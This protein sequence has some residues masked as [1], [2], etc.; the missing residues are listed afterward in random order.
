LLAVEPLEWWHGRRFGVLRVKDEVAGYAA[1]EDGVVVAI[2]GA[3][4]SNGEVWLFAAGPVRPIFHRSALV[5]LKDLAA[6]GVERVWARPDAGIAKSDLW[7]TRLGFR[8]HD[9]ANREGAWICELR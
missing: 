9:A 2:G 7:L 6:S 5:L 8:P 1:L 4:E 3:T